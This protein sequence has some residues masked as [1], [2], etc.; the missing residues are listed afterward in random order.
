MKKKTIQV[1]FSSFVF[2][3]CLINWSI[4]PAIEAVAV[5]QQAT[6]AVE[7]LPSASSRTE[8]EESA[9]ERSTERSTSKATDSV[10]GH[11]IAG[12]PSPK[13]AVGSPANRDSAEKD[14]D[15]S[16]PGIGGTTR[17][18]STG[19]ST[20]AAAIGTT[21]SGGQ[22]TGASSSGD[23]TTGAAAT[24]ASSSGDQTTG[25][26]SSG[27]QAT[28][29]SWS[30]SQTTGTASSSGQ[31]TGT[32]SSSGETTGA[33]SVG[34]PSPSGEASSISS[35]ETA[36]KPSP[37]AAPG[38]N[39]T[40]L[41]SET[42]VAESTSDSPASND[43]DR[44]ARSAQPGFTFATV[45]GGL[46]ITDWNRVIGP[47]YSLVIPDQHEG[48]PIV[49]IAPNVFQN[50]RINHLTI[51]SNI[52]E[53]GAYAFAVCFIRTITFARGE[54]GAPSALQK[55]DDCAFRDCRL[56][57]VS[58]PEG[59]LSI[60]EF[61][62]SNN[63]LT[64]IQLGDKVQSLGEGCFSHDLLTAITLPASITS[65]GAHILTDN[66]T[67]VSVTT[68]SAAVPK[69]DAKEGAFGH[70]VDPVLIKVT[71]VNKATNEAIGPSYY[72]GELS[73]EPVFS[74]DAAASWTPPAIEG[75]QTPQPLDFTPSELPALTN[76]PNT[77]LLNAG[78]IP[79]QGPP[80]L[81]VAGPITIIPVLTNEELPTYL[82]G[83]VEQATDYKGDDLKSKVTVDVRAVELSRSG[84]YNVTFSV[85][86]NDGKTTSIQVQVI[87]KT[88]GWDT[89]PVAN[90]WTL[91]DFTYNG[92]VLTGLSPSGTQKLSRT[93][94]VV[95]PP[96]SC[97][98]D[99][100][101]VHKIATRAFIDP[102]IKVVDLSKMKE[103]VEIEDEAF[104]RASGAPVQVVFG[105]LPAL[106]RIGDRAFACAT[107]PNGIRPIKKTIDLKGLPSLQV[108]GKEAFK[109]IRYRYVDMKDL[110]AL[111]VIGSKAFFGFTFEGHNYPFIIGHTT[112]TTVR[113]IGDSAFENASIEHVDLRRYVDLVSIAPRAFYNVGMKRLELPQ[114]VG[115]RAPALSNIGDEAFASN[116]CESVVI[117]GA[118]NLERIGARAFA[119]NKISRLRLIGLS[120]LQNIGS[121]CFANDQIVDTR[122]DDL[123]QLSEIQG[124][125]FQGNPG[126]P[127]YGDRVVIWHYP[128]ERNRIVSRGNFIVNP[129]PPVSNT[130]VAAD[131]LYEDDGEQ[132]S[133]LG[134][135]SSGMAKYRAG[136]SPVV[137]PAK[138]G[139]GKTIT[140]IGSMAF[141]LMS[142]PAFDFSQLARLQ[143][144]GYR[145][146]RG[147]HIRGLDFQKL[148]DLT[149]LDEEAFA[150]TDLTTADLHGLSRLAFLGRGLFAD[151]S[152]TI[153]SL[154][155][156]PALTD[157]P[158][159]F[160][161]NCPLTRLE[162]GDLS[163]LERI[164]RGAFQWA[165]DVPPPRLNVRV[166][167]LSALTRIDEAAFEGRWSA[168][169]PFSKLTALQ[170]I[171]PR[172][173]ADCGLE[174]LDLSG[175]T[176]L[177]TLGQGSFANNRLKTLRLPA[178]APLSSIPA[179]AFAHNDLTQ[180]EVG[181][182]IR[183][184]EPTAFQWNT[185]PLAPEQGGEE[186]AMPV[187]ILTPGHRNPNGLT[188]AVDP[189]KGGHLIDP[190]KVRIRFLIGRP[191][192]HTPTDAEL[193]SAAYKLYPKDQTGA[194]IPAP[195]IV[196]YEPTAPQTHVGFVQGQQDYNVDLVY[197]KKDYSTLGTSS[198]ADLFHKNQGARATWVGNIMITQLSLSLSRAFEETKDATVKVFFDPT[199]IDLNKTRVEQSPTTGSDQVV[200]DPSGVI[201]IHF[202]VL[203]GGDYYLIPIQWAY[204]LGA[205][206]LGY[207]QSL[208]TLL[209][210]KAGDPVTV[211]RDPAGEVS[212]PSIGVDERLPLIQIGS[213]LEK[214]AGYEGGYRDFGQQTATLIDGKPTRYINGATPLPF[215]FYIGQT[216]TI[217]GLD[218]NIERLVLT[219]PLPS[220]KAV[221]DG[222]VV[223]RTASFDPA[224]N[225]GWSTGPES[226]EVT[227]VIDYPVPHRVLADLPRL[228]LSFPGA[229]INSQV[230]AMVKAVLTPA[231]HTEQ[232]G[233]IVLH[234][235]ILLMVAPRRVYYGPDRILVKKKALDREFIDSTEGKSQLFS[236][237]LSLDIRDGDFI[238]DDG[239]MRLVFKDEDLDK[240]MVYH[241][242]V[243]PQAADTAVVKG[244][245]K[246][247][248]MIEYGNTN[249][250]TYVVR[251]PERVS[252]LTVDMQGRE[253]REDWSLIIKTKLR[254]PD[255]TSYDKVNILN[256]L[257]YNYACAD[258]EWERGDGTQVTGT[259]IT[260][261]DTMLMLPDELSIEPQLTTSYPTAD[262]GLTAD[263]GKQGSFDLKVV[264]SYDH[265]TQIRPDQNTPLKDFSMIQLLPES[266]DL[267]AQ[268]PITLTRE[269]RRSG[270][271]Y[272]VLNDYRGSGRTAIRFSAD[273]LE[274]D[275]Q[276]VATVH[277]V[278]DPSAPAGTS[279]SD[280]YMAFDSKNS[281]NYHYGARASSESIDGLP[282]MHTAVAVSIRDRDLMQARMYIA[283]EGGDWAMNGIQIAPGESFRYKLELDNSSL[284]EKSNNRLIDVLPQPGDSVIQIDQFGVRAARGSAF[285]IQLTSATLQDQNGRPRSDF[286]ILYTTD[287]IGYPEG[288]PSGPYLEGLSWKPLSGAAPAGVTAVMV[289]P[290]RGSEGKLKVGEKLQLILGAK[291]PDDSSLAGSAACNTF[292]R[293]DDS[294]NEYLETNRV[295]STI[296]VPTGSISLKKVSAAL[297][298][299]PS[300]AL[301]D[302][303]FTLYDKETGRFVTSGTT[304]GRGEL[305][306][307]DL[308]VKDY[309]LVE[310]APPEGFMACDPIQISRADWLGKPELAFG[311]GTVVDQTDFNGKLILSKVDAAG[312]PLSGAKFSLVRIKDGK[313]DPTQPTFVRTTGSDGRAEW[314]GLDRGEYQLRETR[315]PGN[316]VPLGIVPVDSEQTFRIDRPGQ[317]IDLTGAKRMVNDRARIKLYKLGLNPSIRLDDSKGLSAYTANQGS[318]VIND[319]VYELASKD[320]SEP[321]REIRRDGDHWLLD[322][323]QVG[324]VYTLKEVS[325]NEHTIYRLNKKTYTF[326]L[327]AKGLPQEEDGTPFS[328]TTILFPNEAKR[329]K[330]QIT[331]KK[332]DPQGT[333]L[334][335][336]AFGVELYDSQSRGYRPV[337]FNEE[338]GSYEFSNDQH[339]PFSV[340]TGTD[341][342]AVIKD[343][344]P[345]Y[346]N[347]VE[348]SPPAGYRAVKT[349][350][351]VDLG[352]DVLPDILNNPNYIVGPRTIIYNA[353]RKVTNAPIDLQLTKRSTVGRGLSEV[354]ASHMV[355][356]FNGRYRMVKEKGRYTV[357][358]PIA[359]ARFD[360]YQLKE[361]RKVKVREDMV[362][363]NEG[364]ITGGTAVGGPATGGPAAGQLI[365][366][367]DGI[368]ELRETKT[369]D[370]SWKLPTLPLRIDVAQQ[371]SRVPSGPIQ[372]Y[373]ENN[374]KTGQLTISKYDRYT[375]DWLAGA[376]FSLYKGV[377]DSEGK[378][379]ADGPAVKTGTTDANGYLVFA[380][381]P[382]GLYILKETATPSPDYALPDQSALL[383]LEGDHTQWIVSVFN[384]RKA[385]LFDLPVEKRWIGT[386][387]SD[388]DPTEPGDQGLELSL[389]YRVKGESAEHLLEKQ[390]V[391]P[392]RDGNW[393]TSFKSLY[394]TSFN[395][396][397]Y[398][399]RVVETV[400]TG[401]KAM[402]GEAEVY[403]DK[404]G[405]LRWFNS[406]TT[407]GDP[408]GGE[409]AGEPVGAD[410]VQLVNRQLTSVSIQAE[411]TV[412]GRELKADDYGFA[413]YKATPEGSLLQN[414]P[415]ME[416]RN[417]APVTTPDGRTVAPVVFDKV[418]T[419]DQNGEENALYYLM[420]EVDE[421]KPF[422]TYDDHSY[423]VKVYFEET[424]GTA[425]RPVVEY[426]PLEEVGG[427]LAPGAVLNEVPV[428][429][430]VYES[431][432]EWT[433]RATKRFEDGQL[434][435][436]DFTFQLKK[437]GQLIQQKTNASDGS[438]SFDPIFI[439]SAAVGSPVT[440]QLVE[441]NDG[442]T[443]VSYDERIYDVVVKVSQAAD[444]DLS[445]EAR[446]ELQGEE[447]KEGAVFV[448]RKLSPPPTEPTGGT[449]TQPSI[450]PSTQPTTKP[451]ESSGT[452]P[453]TQ[454]STQPTTSTTISSGTSTQ[455]STPTG[456]SADGSTSTRPSTSPITPAHS[457]GPPAGPS[458]GPRPQ[459]PDQ[460]PQTGQ[461]PQPSLFAALLLA[462]ALIAGAGVICRNRRKQR[463]NN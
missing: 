300:F 354:D 10:V 108:I 417:Q 179:A 1:V 252:R 30:G 13:I 103:L 267:R 107:D 422:T 55:I 320:G 372:I 119:D 308:Q 241:S 242:V 199:Y 191:G 257:Y 112:L 125:V 381:L 237:Q 426:R 24:G 358:Q 445:V 361:G 147:T 177:A 114:P 160:C 333:P 165:K 65:C 263:H 346:C 93:S 270:G 334:A 282:Y 87:V 277:T 355:E 275:V 326:K 186:A 39:S 182:Q 146:F 362:S 401:Y 95:L 444:G 368:Y 248:N 136:V 105:S 120:S 94:S 453:S 187:M 317:V 60:G 192:Q 85:T 447:A 26:S 193:R 240:R 96:Y 48:I 171:G 102:R 315:A 70:V 369:A 259:S 106:E 311:L 327:D 64:S 371:L 205:T 231:D 57:T 393:K 329:V 321:A 239:H 238:G 249:N 416:V 235:D 126:D 408:A 376:E 307:E 394:K 133:I 33:P 280:L 462:F 41:S 49:S 53:I 134:F 367:A 305:K 463:K 440:Y 144:V 325:Q 56:R 268:D 35:A 318:L 460:L 414:K 418:A 232:E 43:M 430:N 400:P 225:P 111:Q 156:T 293:K 322:G 364:Q 157:I 432:V 332:T 21:S 435:G 262:Q 215:T 286:E 227:R 429:H 410:G 181:A 302:A 28:G 387:P 360:L 310:T 222:R 402:K 314:G 168:T 23:Q 420:K 188:D 172:A 16:D 330:G 411:K 258:Y 183:S 178:T 79:L 29:T 415:L 236:W 189:A 221:E 86:D 211:S 101:F 148:T 3:I 386:A 201:S 343:L 198:R 40:H 206:P 451:T 214:S 169:I 203:R 174:A 210:N 71:P 336:A 34:R 109:G 36:D 328:G 290:V 190:Y 357:Y 299:S 9:A 340:T 135:S 424:T 425:L 350:I 59:L 423:L 274:Y 140:A 152:L 374:K 75:Y 341:G 162:V 316:L 50:I 390:I 337:W 442:R 389:Y 143:K 62:F 170:T 194:D 459:S 339:P 159:D 12:T 437:D 297:H 323:L 89:T 272:E 461:G 98:G 421:G 287:T 213:P 245:N 74:K 90:G 285:G 399:Y 260:D 436:G 313:P 78:Y 184:I 283:K 331:V 344:P 37:A 455:P 226:G 11:E 457:G 63:L 373:F 303:G 403:M 279:Q 173:F 20:G 254:D 92:D 81:K 18:R 306:L 208:P 255:A 27:D 439:G 118:R 246:N 295:S 266:I 61:A 104:Y 319:I 158:Q 66:P 38:E 137:L 284:N 431:R 324:K 391:E 348:L 25:A 234:D 294:L 261:W 151:S 296:V 382:L 17:G 220:Y 250:G 121:S 77:R 449:G 276:T 378:V 269:F 15:G 145:A 298:G 116:Q 356:L 309:I 441:V 180:I 195:A 80:V 443:D 409:G 397:P 6:G 88:E 185:D 353:E 384:Q 338:T 448:N 265:S 142:G 14:P 366:E 433:P 124:D 128:L 82:L 47:D 385:E 202:P 22:T 345:G 138:D 44:Q 230:T 218:R 392:D 167:S 7:S 370:S 117:T 164:R 52:K 84:S 450:Q 153:L 404:N 83:Y 175:L 163:R 228:K 19:G 251:D 244:Y 154:G 233:D 166:G 396:K 271:R 129:T 207:R 127:T 419:P 291:A 100:P 264:R 406:A 452:Q 209:Y 204:R 139:S 281:P 97:E 412:S 288:R 375:R 54:N 335:G 405:V 219:V 46:Q 273:S 110:P 51:G 212:F 388:C 365:W 434:S 413:L 73:G 149:R 377:K 347:L 446:Y 243:L 72:I 113:E 176:G 383:D 223:T 351:K 132:N 349:K 407:G 122:F 292:V 197:Y 141:D 312:Q 256:N 196:G 304:N 45:E 224:L 289:R 379:R 438:I 458:S 42:T 150:E 130:Y 217:P 76:D 8:D 363:D 398:V 247:G 301:K 4:A 216:Q 454:P 91:G 67:F 131:F 427:Q 69:V 68:T 380:D 395:G 278:V 359:G 200:I 342:T 229:L 5:H 352:G 155:E 123:S 115:S 161:Q 58:L 428:F 253:F 99:R 31:T 32:S 2:L 456:P